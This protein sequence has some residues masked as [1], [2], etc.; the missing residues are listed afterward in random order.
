M[1]FF[2][3]ALGASSAICFG[4]LFWSG[5]AYAA[6]PLQT[7]DTG[8]QDQGNW[9]LEMNADR[10]TTR[11][12]GGNGQDVARKA[13]TTL[14]YGALPTLDTFVNLPWWWLDNRNSQGDRDKVSGR[15]ELA[16]GMKW[17]AWETEE[18]SNA[19]LNTHLNKFS[20]GFKTE[21]SLPTSADER[22][23]GTGR[24]NLTL[25]GLLNYEWN[26]WVWL[27]NLS[28]ATNRAPSLPENHRNRV[29]G[30]STALLYKVIEGWR[31][32]ADTGVTQGTETTVANTRYFLLGV[33]YS[34]KEAL[35]FDL[36]WRANRQG[37]TR[38][39]TLGVGVTVRF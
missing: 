24:T 20:L 37:V 38:Q 35:D 12:M 1:R 7:D 15:G 31:L 29:A 4:L 16:L 8:T 22:G 17:R 10:T 14:T 27:A 6:H 5:T 26:D 9:Q 11:E 34:P 19:H 23:I 25:T 39:N 28:L 18:H 36:G 32:A 2:F 3:R 21:L 30:I 13:N 33:I